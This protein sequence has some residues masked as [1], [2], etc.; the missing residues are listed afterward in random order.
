MISLEAAQARLVALANPLPVETVSYHWLKHPQFADAVE[1][2]LKRETAG[3]HRYVN[4]L[5]EHSPYKS[6]D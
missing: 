3:I 2:F 4:E 6:R 1:N 5:S